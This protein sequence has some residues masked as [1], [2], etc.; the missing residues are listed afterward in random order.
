MIYFFGIDSAIR[1]AT[2]AYGTPIEY[3]CLANWY[4]C[5]KAGKFPARF[6]RDSTNLMCAWQARVVG[7]SDGAAYAQFLHAR[8][9]CGALHAEEIG[10]TLRTSDAPL[11][12][13]KSAEDMLA[14]SFLQGGY[15]C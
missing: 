15:G 4:S 14:L 11:G 5:E 12:L 9:E 3:S 7:A 6:R 2:L 8:L 10:G 1:E 13:P